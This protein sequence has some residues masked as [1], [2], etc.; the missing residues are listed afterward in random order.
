MFHVD[1]KHE[2][3]RKFRRLSGTDKHVLVQRASPNGEVGRAMT[4]RVG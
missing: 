3:L 4:T 1:L 2:G